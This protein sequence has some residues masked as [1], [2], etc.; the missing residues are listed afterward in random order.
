M[1]ANSYDELIEYP[2]VKQ[3]VMIEFSSQVGKMNQSYILTVRG[4][5]YAAS[6]YFG[7]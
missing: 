2:Y 7:N 3:L 4:Y 1:C 6:Y 5:S